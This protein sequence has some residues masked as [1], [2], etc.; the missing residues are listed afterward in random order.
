MLESFKSKP[1]IAFAAALVVALLVTPLV[2]R[3]AWKV[4]A[5]AKPDT[6]RIHAEPIAQWGGLA[7]FIGVA[8]AALLWRQPSANDFRQLSTSSAPSDIQ[9]VKQTVHLTAAFFGC[10]FL[11]LL[12]GMADDRWEFKPLW[13]FGGQIAIASLLWFLGLKIQTLP[14][15]SGTQPL[16]DPASFGLT[17]LWVLGLTNAMNLI[18]GMDG[19][20]SGIAAIAASS[21]AI[22]EVGKA[23]WAAA[24]AASIA[25]AG[26]GF[27]RWN[28]PPAKIFLGDAGALLLGF[29]L[30][31]VSLAAASKT[32]A[33][34]TLMLPML[35]LGVPLLDTLWAILRRAASHQP[36]WRADRG[37]FH[38][39][40]LARGYSTQKVLLVLYSAAVALGATAVA[41]TKLRG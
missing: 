32:A 1:Q 8:A 18:D 7:V 9:A 34:T 41:I 12:L 10:G 22:I 11:M 36:I 27:L 40:L 31:V 15:T 6:R 26:F 19:L 5:L 17:L 39:R 35:V 14:F 33:A 21:L 23:P 2:R 37:H 24:V 30:A 28:Y 20:A 25:G 29:W 3:L 16:S 38:H 13:K 4:G